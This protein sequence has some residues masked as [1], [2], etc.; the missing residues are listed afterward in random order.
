[1]VLPAPTGELGSGRGRKD[2][3][4]RGRTVS[5]AG[6]SRLGWVATVRHRIP[7]PKHMLA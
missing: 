2:S 1:M 6:P 4:P 5:P 7:L 3:I